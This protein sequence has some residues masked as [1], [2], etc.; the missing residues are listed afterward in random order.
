MQTTD[1]TVLAFYTQPAAMTSPGRYASLLSD[2]P[3]DLPGLAAVVQGLLIHEHMAARLRGDP[4]RGRPGQ[5]AHPSRGGLLAQIVA[6]D[7]P[8]AA[9][10]R[11]HPR[12]G[13]PATAGISP[14]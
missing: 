12:A 3:R 2:L 1:Q 14:S 4:V 6:R 8:A 13:C 11:G 9:R 7:E 5:R 10:S